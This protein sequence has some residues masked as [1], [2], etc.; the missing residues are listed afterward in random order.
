MANYYSSAYRTVLNTAWSGLEVHFFQRGGYSFKII[1]RTRIFF[2]Q[3]VVKILEIRKININISIKKLNC[4]NF[5]VASGIVDN[6]NIQFSA[7]HIK[8]CYY[9]RNVGSRTYKVDIMSSLLLKLKENF[10]KT[11]FSNFLT[12]IF[13]G[14]FIILAKTAFQITAGKE[15]RSRTSGA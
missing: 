12:T 11:N 6:G 3:R 9:L 10:G 2:S 8:S 15:N 5:F 4:F 1:V 13:M 7:A 14:Y